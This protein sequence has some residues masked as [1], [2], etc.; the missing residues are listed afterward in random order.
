MSHLPTILSEMTAI[1][2]SYHAAVHP[3]GTLIDMRRMLAGWNWSL[4]TYVKQTYGSKALTYAKRK[5][6]TAKYIVGEIERDE[7]TTGTKPRP[8]SRLEQQAEASQQVLDSRRAEALAD[9]E[10]EGVKAMLF[11]AKEVLHAMS[12]EIAD[13]RDERNYQEHPATTQQHQPPTK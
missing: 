2:D 13:A 6:D 10:Y 1:V 8:M 12:Q 5:H 3:I 4:S 7:Q 9:A 11:A